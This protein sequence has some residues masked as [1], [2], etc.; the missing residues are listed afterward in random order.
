MVMVVLCGPPDVPPCVASTCAWAIAP[1]CVPGRVHMYHG[2]FHMT[3]PDQKYVE[4]PTAG[5]PAMYAVAQAQVDVSA[6][7]VVLHRL[8]HGQKSSPFLVTGQF[9]KNLEWKNICRKIYVYIPGIYIMYIYRSNGIVTVLV[10]LARSVFFFF[11]FAEWAVP[12]LRG[13]EGGNQGRLR[14]ARAGGEEDQRESLRQARRHPS[15]LVGELRGPEQRDLGPN[16]LQHGGVAEQHD[17]S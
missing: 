2:W 16:D 8:T 10:P 17:R 6:A 9:L 7:V 1:D 13:S 3:S 15:P 4:R 14:E 5:S 11:V 12:R